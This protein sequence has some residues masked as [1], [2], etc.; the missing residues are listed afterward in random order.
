MVA[1]ADFNIIYCNK[2][3]STMF[4]NAERELRKVLPRFDADKLVGSNMDIFHGIRATS[5]DCSNTC[6]PQSAARWRWPGLTLRVVANPVLA[7][8]GGRLGTVVEWA[9]RTEEVAVE[10]EID[11]IVDAAAWRSG[12]SGVA[13]G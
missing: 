3:L 9:N 5:G 12:Q 1:D 6:S 11:G 7:D 8:N 13:A 10:A 4:Q 2:T